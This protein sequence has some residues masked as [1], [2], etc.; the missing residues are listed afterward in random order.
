MPTVRIMYIMSNYPLRWRRALSRFVLLSLLMNAALIPCLHAAE[1]EERISRFYEDALARFNRKDYAGAEIQTKNVLQ[2][3][4]RYLPA[5]VLLGRIQLQ[6]GKSADAERSFKTALQLGVDRSEVAAA[7]GEA[8]F[9]QDKYAAV[10]EIDPTGLPA[11]TKVEVL[12]LRAYSYLE[13]GN[14]A[15]AQAALDEARRVNPN[16]ASIAQAQ[17]VVLLRQNKPAEAKKFID[18]ALAATPDSSK[19]WNLKATITHAMGDANN[20]LKEYGRAIQ[21]DPN[22]SEPRI[23]RAALLLDLGRDKEALEDLDQ[24]KGRAASDPRRAYLR[25]VI[26]AKRRDSVRVQQSL[27]EVIRSVDAIP[28]DVLN[29][30]LQ[31]LLIGGMA[32]YSLDHREKA[33]Q[34]L[35]RFLILDPKHIGVRKVLASILLSERNFV[36]AIDILQPVREATP[37]DTYTLSL[38]TTAY[39]GLNQRDTAEKLMEQAVASSQN[40]PAMESS[41]GFTLL[42]GGDI[43]NG[44][45]RLRQAFETDPNQVQAGMAVAILELKRNQPKAALA[46]A[47]KL[48]QKQPDNA[49][50]QNLLGAIQGVLGNVPASRAAY[51]KAAA[52]NPAYAAPQLNLARGDLARGKLE[53]AQTR[54]SALLKRDP[55]NVQVLFELARVQNAAG[56][57][58]EAAR[59]LEKARALA[60]RNM[61]IAGALMD[62]YLTRKNWDKVIQ[63]AAALESD[64]SGSYS[65]LAALGRAYLGLGENKKAAATFD[66]MATAAGNNPGFLTE[67]ATLQSAA[68]NVA[69]ARTL[70]TRAIAGNPNFLPAQAQLT[71]LDLN[72]G[73]R[74]KAETR[75]KELSARFPGDAIVLELQGDIAFA[76]NNFP[77]AIAAYRAAYAKRADANT[78]IRLARA[79]VKAGNT[80]AAIATL[81]QGIKTHSQDEWLRRA[82]AETQMRA[83]LNQAAR[84]SYENILKTNPND[85]GALNNLA[86]LLNQSQEASALSYIE[87][88][89]RLAP[90]NAAV[91]DT[92]GWILSTQN[93]PGKALLYLREARLRDP[94]NGE[95]RYH[96]AYVLQRLNRKEEA[97]TEL[98]AALEMPPFPEQVQARELMSNLG[99]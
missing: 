47:N 43:D 49:L 86:A 78:L 62:I 45:T 44:I 73:D 55:K 39:L 52:I 89:Y 41:L 27:D 59:D 75:V 36:K 7:L 98:A 24:V 20:A 5:Q 92:Y 54:L 69:G 9:N 97:K 48:V 85:V 34:Y 12:V 90:E 68:G 70:L 13:L 80:A 23:A 56:R 29:R 19:G 38:L 15:N 1:S 79:Q 14:L 30:H 63:L 72:Q 10:N 37:N 28:S 42:S 40:N 93:Q 17:A 66:R 77:E 4:P 82:L 58:A 22:Y 81:E 25:A 50:Y 57:Y 87:R 76:K 60:P 84:L 94:Q 67:T 18:Y 2:T 91:N 64:A 65:G 46:I 71:A 83:G 11:K 6:L 16:S 35:Q 88:A 3:N 53:A 32:H 99:K 21:L 33:Q 61:E 51:E 95:I 26:Y 96:L 8:Y 31:L 74:A